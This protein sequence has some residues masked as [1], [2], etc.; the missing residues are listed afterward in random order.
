[1][2][3]VL[4]EGIRKNHKTI[5]YKSTDGK[6]RTY[7]FES[8]AD[9]VITQNDNHIGICSAFHKRCVDVNFTESSCSKLSRTTCG[10]RKYKF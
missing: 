7:K 5:E 10:C 4:I 6:S 3:K 2:V 1:M 9:A 8:K